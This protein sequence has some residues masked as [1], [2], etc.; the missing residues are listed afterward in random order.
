MSIV[1]VVVVVFAVGLLVGVDDAGF[2]PVKR[3]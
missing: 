2:P 3:P 1:V